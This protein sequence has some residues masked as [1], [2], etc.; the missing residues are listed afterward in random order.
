MYYLDNQN[1][2]KKFIEY[3]QLNNCC[4][5]SNEKNHHLLNRDT[6]DIMPLGEI[7]TFKEK[8]LAIV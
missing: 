5:D 6:N 4:G 3:Y 1:E 2:R 7:M 8:P